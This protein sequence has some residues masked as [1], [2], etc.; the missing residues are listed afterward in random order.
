M[1]AITIERLRFRILDL[2]INQT[3]N[4]R[5]A[6]HKVDWEDCIRWGKY[7]QDQTSPY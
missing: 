3:P 6:C 2:P 1:E 4:C 5:I 7:I